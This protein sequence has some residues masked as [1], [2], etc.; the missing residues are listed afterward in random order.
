LKGVCNTE[1]P[2]KGDLCR[3]YPVVVLN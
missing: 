2:I 3:G 1:E